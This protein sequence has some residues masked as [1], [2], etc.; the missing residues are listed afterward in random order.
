MKNKFIIVSFYAGKYYEKVMNE[1]LLPSIQ[2]LKL[3][4]YIEKIDNLGNWRKNANQKL[5]FIKKCLEKFSDKNIVFIDADAKINNYPELFDNIPKEYLIGIHY[6][7]WDKWYKNGNKIKEL[8]TGTI[9]LKNCEETKELINNWIK[10][11]RENKPQQ[12]T[13]Q[14]LIEIEDL[15][16]YKLPLEYCY[17]VNLPNGQEPHIKI[18]NPIIS[19]YQISRKIKRNKRLLNI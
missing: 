18:E 2:K 13:L 11:T 10:E 15:N 17:I 16:I 7:D 9:Y 6:L 5:L 12:K 1:Y 3:P 8:L 19:H 14:K 4:F